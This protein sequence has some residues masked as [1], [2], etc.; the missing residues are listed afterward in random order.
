MRQALEARSAEGREEKSVV[1]KL[2]PGSSFASEM[3]RERGI[4]V[5]RKRYVSTVCCLR[6]IRLWWA[7]KGRW[8][9]V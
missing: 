1:W 8:I 6:M 9:K 5:K 2:M 4:V 3:V 7:R